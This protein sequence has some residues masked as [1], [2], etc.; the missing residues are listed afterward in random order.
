MTLSVSIYAS[1]LNTEQ[2]KRAPTL[3]LQ[4]KRK[5]IKFNIPGNT[6]DIDSVKMIEVFFEIV[7]REY[8]HK[9]YVDVLR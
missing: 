6:S 2:T 5:T 8:D 4:F 7:S 3:L 1:T 9:I